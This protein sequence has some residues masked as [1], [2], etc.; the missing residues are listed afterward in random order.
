M[1]LPLNSMT[2]MKSDNPI[3]LYVRISAILK[4]LKKIQLFFRKYQLT[5]EM[6]IL[7][8]LCFNT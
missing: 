4:T 2:E 1:L 3:K 8:L 5:H 7:F 6:F